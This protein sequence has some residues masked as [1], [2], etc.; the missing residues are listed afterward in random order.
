MGKKGRDDEAVAKKQVRYV[1]VCT[2]ATG[3]VSRI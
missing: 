3:R 2:N 1:V